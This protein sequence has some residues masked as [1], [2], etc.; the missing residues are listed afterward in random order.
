VDS[1]HLTRRYVTIKYLV[2]RGT[3]TTGVDPLS[4]HDA[5]PIYAEHGPPVGRRGPQGGDPAPGPRRRDRQRDPPERPP[6]RRHRDHRLVLDRKST[7]LNSSHVK[8]SYAVFCLKEKKGDDK[9]GATPPK[10]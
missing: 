7:R 5:L 4:L 6:D 2:I 3:P 10:G 8:S 1:P 9:G